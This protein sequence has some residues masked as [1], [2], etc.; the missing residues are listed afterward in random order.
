MLSDLKGFKDNVW[1]GLGLGI[2]IPAIL[3]SIIWYAMHKFSFLAKADLLLIGGIAVNALI[4]HYFFR[5]NKEQ[6]ARGVISATFLWAFAFFFY[7][8]NQP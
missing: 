5:H 4:M 6:A 2:L 7:K 1:A 8:I 3:V